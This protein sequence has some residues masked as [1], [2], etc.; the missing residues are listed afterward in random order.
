MP[1]VPA[2]STKPSGKGINE[3]RHPLFRA[4]VPAATT[5]DTVTFQL[6]AGWVGRGFHLVSGSFCKW[7]SGAA[8]ARTKTLIAFGAT[9]YN[10][11]TG[12]ISVVPAA[13]LDGAGGNEAFFQLAD[14]L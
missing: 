10:E 5:S 9:T 8:G 4:V 11:A 1:T 3:E 14:A 7:T 6:P 2:T 12:L 13:N